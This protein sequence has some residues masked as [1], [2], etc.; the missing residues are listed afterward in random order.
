MVRADSCQAA[1]G[2]NLVSTILITIYH[3]VRGIMQPAM[4]P[5]LPFLSVENSPLAKNP[6]Q[7]EISKFYPFF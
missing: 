3:V 6:P 4:T 5:V 1:N 2:Q 7:R